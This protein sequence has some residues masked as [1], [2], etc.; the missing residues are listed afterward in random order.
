[1]IM[2]LKIQIGSSLKAN[3]HCYVCI[4]VWPRALRL[5]CYNAT[6]HLY[7]QYYHMYESGHLQCHR[8]NLYNTH[9][10]YTEIYHVV[11][12]KRFVLSFNTQEL[13]SHC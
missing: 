7:P 1:M 8:Y 11:D 12:T 3:T 2:V 5:L 4:D 6:H 13:V 9:I 10:C